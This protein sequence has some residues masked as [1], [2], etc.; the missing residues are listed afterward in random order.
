MSN[1]FDLNEH[2]VIAFVPTRDPDRARAFYRDL[3][4]LRL[5]LEQLPFALVFDAHG[6]MLR[7]IVVK[8]LTPPS[9][10]TL[11]WEVPNIEHAVATLKEK[12]VQFERY[13]NMSQDQL[14]IWTAPG[15]SKIAWFRDP[16]GNTLSLSQH[17]LPIAD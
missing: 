14:G 17:S 9:Y 4:G 11:G 3:L 13:P 1:G 12:G 8:E 6:I 10:T 16:D 15:G 2:P 7:V 5:T